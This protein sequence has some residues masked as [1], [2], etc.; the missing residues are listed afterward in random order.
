MATLMWHCPVCP[1]D[2]PDRPARGD[3]PTHRV[4]LIPREESAAPEPGPAVALEAA[5]RRIAL[6]LAGGRVDVPRDGL[7]LGRSLPPLRGLPEMAGLTQISRTA[8]ARLYW[9]SDELY[10]VDAGSTNGTFVDDVRADRPIPLRPG[11]RLRL[12]EDVPVEVVELDE[13]GMV[14]RGGAE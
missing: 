12:A 6:R 8:Q 2:V 4:P 11:S 3:C 7:L 1:D 13:L 14:K 10:I 5:P 9:E